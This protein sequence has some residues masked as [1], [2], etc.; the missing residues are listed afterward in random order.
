MSLCGWWLHV[1]SYHPVKFGVHKACE[2]GD[3]TFLIRH[4]TTNGHLIKEPSYFL[5][6][7][8]SLQAITLLSLV[9]IAIVEVK[10]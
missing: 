1:I 10:I 6:G 2:I 8:S 5:S 7:D 3:K 9:A 4:V